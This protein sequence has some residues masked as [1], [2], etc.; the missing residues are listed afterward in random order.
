MASQL[1]ARATRAEFLPGTCKRRINYSVRVVT[2]AAA[3]FDID[4][5][6]EWLRNETCD[7]GAGP[8]DTLI[9]LIVSAATAEL[10]GPNGSMG[11]ALGEQTLRLTVDR[12]PYGHDPLYLPLTTPDATPAPFV[13][14]SVYYIDPAGDEQVFTDWVYNWDT[15]PVSIS[16]ALGYTWPTT[17][18]QDS[19]VEVNY[20]A[21][22]DSLPDPVQ[23]Y[24]R[25]RMAQMYDERSLVVAG[26]TIAK[27]PYYEAMLDSLRQLVLDPV[28][29]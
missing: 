14:D 10:D 26:V 28:R 4:A 20:L 18:C 1:Q 27:V 19:A 23:I 9:E 12:F 5:A 22:Y 29:S 7:G 11:R 24:L 8:D 17:R 25:L 15:D 21:G 6:R 2:A 13:G 16:P 3:L